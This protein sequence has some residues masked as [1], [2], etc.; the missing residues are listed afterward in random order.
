MTAERVRIWDVEVRLFHWTLAA[1]FTIAYV[2]EVEWPELHSHTGYTV[3]LLVGFRVIWGFVGSQHA[4][5]VDFVTGPRVAIS[6]LIELASANAPHY[7]G[8]NPAGG[9]MVVLLLLSLLVTATTGTILDAMAGSGP[10]PLDV[11]ATWSDRPFVLVHEIAADVTLGLVTLHIAGV[12]VTSI[13]TRENLIMAM[14]RGDK[15]PRR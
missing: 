9:L 2:V 6:H 3:L 8:H 4:R 7:V 13:I 1:F 14:L 5:F 15:A 10:I 12:A 11:V